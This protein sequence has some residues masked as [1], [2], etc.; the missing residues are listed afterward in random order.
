MSLQVDKTLKK[1]IIKRK[2]LEN[3]MVEVPDIDIKHQEG[4]SYLSTL[5][6]KSIDLV[7]T[8]S[9]YY[10]QRQWYEFAL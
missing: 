10:F 6:D 8:D 2:K 9:L 7:L 5:P 4:L 1:V 3:V